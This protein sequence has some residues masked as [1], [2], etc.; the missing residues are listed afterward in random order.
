MEIFEIILIAIGV[1]FDIFA[2]IICISSS[3]SKID[4]KKMLSHGIVFTLWQLVSLALGYYSIEVITDLKIATE[5]S[6]ILHLIAIVIIITLAIRMI[7]AG[8]R[9]DMVVEHRIDTLSVWEIIKS[10]LAIGIRTYFVGMAFEAFET[11]FGIEVLL[12]MVAALLMTYAGLHFGYR[13]GYEFKNKA[14]YIGSAFLI[15][16]GACVGYQAFVI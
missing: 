5:N 13:Y 16:A 9:H 1:S 3:Y 10:G 6:H 7:I 11:N 12:L 8:A 15:C 2:R 14:Y 4:Y